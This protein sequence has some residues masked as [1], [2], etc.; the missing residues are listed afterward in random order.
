MPDE[1]LRG[2]PPHSCLS[3][4]GAARLGS[5]WLGG[6]GRGARVDGER[7]RRSRERVA[8]GR[9]PPG[10]GLKAGRQKLA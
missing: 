3:A 2:L 6:E 9:K 10:M 7:R 5:I 4:G 8:G 1:L